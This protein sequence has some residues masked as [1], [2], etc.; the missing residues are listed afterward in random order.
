MKSL[1]F[2]LK[3]IQLL[4]LTVTGTWQ[5]PW[6]RHARSPCN[7]TRGQRTRCTCTSAPR[8]HPRRCTWS[9]RIHYI[10]N[11][12]KRCLATF[13]TLHHFVPLLD[14]VQINFQHES[15]KGTK[16]VVVWFRRGSYKEYSSVTLFDNMG[17]YVTDGNFLKLKCPPSSSS[18]PYFCASS[19]LNGHNGKTS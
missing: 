13:L 5:R 17:Q 19:V 7:R 12:L 3:N 10:D 4:L 15:K 14:L 16:N 11:F 9:I 2:V 18:L 6:P 8:R 1:R